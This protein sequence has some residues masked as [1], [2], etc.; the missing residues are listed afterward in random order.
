MAQSQA[1]AFGELLVG[2]VL[3]TAGITGH[4]VRDVLGGRSSPI[5]PLVSR[6]P[7]VGAPGGDAASGA[8]GQGAAFASLTPGTVGKGGVL[9]ELF[10]D[11]IGW[12]IDQGSRV[13]GQIGNHGDHVHIGFDPGTDPRVVRSVI[14]LA[15]R[16]G[17]RVSEGPGAGGASPGV[18]VGGSLHYEALAYD[19]SGSPAAMARFFYA[20]LKAYG[21]GPRPAKQTQA[22]GF[23]MA[24]AA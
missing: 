13:G 14:G 4:S 9:N 22:G 7:P 6:P 24:K 5:K 15:R 17:L 8:A 2:G 3:L 1:L 10:Y 18:H 19:V 21:R 11:P 16:Y 12:Y 20:A 23:S